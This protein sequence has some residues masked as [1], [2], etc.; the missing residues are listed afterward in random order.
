MQK[1]IVD[2]SLGDMATALVKL[3]KNQNDGGNDDDKNESN[4]NDT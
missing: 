4:D 3:T 2:D 1:Q